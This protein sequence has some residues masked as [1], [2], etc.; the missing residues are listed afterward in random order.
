MKVELMSKSEAKHCPVHLHRKRNK[1]KNLAED[2]KALFPGAGRENW[3]HE[4]LKWSPKASRC[5][6][7]VGFQR[8]EAGRQR[9]G[10]D[11]CPPKP[12]MGFSKAE[13]PSCQKESF[14]NCPETGVFGWGPDTR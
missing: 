14:P 12:Q 8:A 10:H 6:F 5:L 4:M 13:C 1:P 11:D 9:D 2:R 3:G 7:L